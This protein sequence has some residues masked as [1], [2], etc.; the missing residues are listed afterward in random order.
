[1]Q[2]SDMS[3]YQAQWLFG[4]IH[5]RKGKVVFEILSLGSLEELLG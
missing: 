1:M 4:K 2:Y 3:L 5:P